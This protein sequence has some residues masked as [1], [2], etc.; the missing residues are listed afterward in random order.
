MRVLIGSIGGFNQT[1]L[2]KLIAFSSINHLGW[3]IST[4][5][6]REIYWNIYFIIYSIIIILITLIFHILN[7]IFINQLFSNNLN[8]IIKLSIFL[9]ILSLGGLPPF[10]G[11]F[12][13]WIIINFIIN[14]NILFFVFI[15]VISTLITLFF[16]I[17]IIYSSFIVNYF[18]LKWFKI[19]IK[20]NSINIIN[21]FTII[22]L[23]TLSFRIILPP[24]F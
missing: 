10:L 9:N 17:R 14:N 1:S 12:S 2:R 3:L 23:F 5:L 20:N 19:F 16:Y 24:I 7:I 8:K 6:I 22:S 4:L 15:F 13:K 21:T 11:F 18:K